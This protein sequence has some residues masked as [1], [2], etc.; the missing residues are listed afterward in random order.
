MSVF[1]QYKATY[2]VKIFLLIFTLLPTS[3][4]LHANILIQKKD[5]KFIL[6]KHLSYFSCESSLEHYDHNSVQGK[7]L[8]SDQVSPFTSYWLTLPEIDNQSEQKNWIISLAWPLLDYEIYTPQKDGTYKKFIGGADYEDGNRVLP[9][10]YYAIPLKIGPGINKSIGIKVKSLGPIYHPLK[11]QTQESFEKDNNFDLIFLSLGYGIILALLLMTLGLSILLRSKQF[12]YLTAFIFS[13]IVT[14]SILHGFAGYFFDTFTFRWFSISLLFLG[15]LTILYGENI[16]N[17]TD[18]NDP[19]LARV[20]FGVSV[21]VSFAVVF[22]AP[23]N[24][25]FYT[26]TL[27]YL[28]TIVVSLFLIIKST[29]DNKFHILTQSI[30]LCILNISG[31]FLVLFLLGFVSSYTPEYYFFIGSLFFVFYS[32]YIAAKRFKDL[33]VL[34]EN[35][36][37]ELQKQIT[38][39]TYELDHQN[40]K[41]TQV[42]DLIDEGILLIDLQGNI[43]EGFS[44]KTIEIFNTADLKLNNLGNLLQL[45]SNE[46]AEFTQWLQL[47]LLPNLQQQWKKIKQLFPLNERTLYFKDQRKTLTLDIARFNQ[48]KLMFRI[49]DITEKV[50]K[51]QALKKMQKNNYIE[52]EFIKAMDHFG[53]EAWILFKNELENLINALSN[54]LKTKNPTAQEFDSLR[55]IL[56]TVKANAGMFHME[57]IRGNLQ[58]W[59][60]FITNRKNHFTGDESSQLKLKE[61]VELHEK[62][63]KISQVFLHNFEDKYVVR[64]EALAQHIEILKNAHANLF[65]LSDSIFNLDSIAIEEFR[66]KID[67][68]AKNIAALCGKKIMP[69]SLQSDMSYI[70]KKTAVFFEGAVIQMIRNAI[71]HGIESN[72][73]RKELN[74]NTAKI[75]ITF[76]KTAERISLS[77]ADDGRGIDLEKI[78]ELDPGCS[79]KPEDIIFAK[80]FSTKMK[81]GN[82]SGMGIGL[83]KLRQDMLKFKGNIE[84][85]SHKGQGC[86]FTFWV[87]RE[88]F[89]RDI[90]RQYEFHKI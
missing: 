88:Y 41:L 54:Y 67:F 89:E 19:R 64:A 47:N 80:N 37:N 14:N 17:L 57:S 25:S 6:N 23:Y 77:V 87:N 26:S 31:L 65:Y 38:E 7:P 78:I 11:L 45:N 12:A 48:N 4:S 18:D 22:F 59:Y 13:V 62:F 33:T 75:A 58:Y 43:Q 21:S 74:K 86:I 81:K 56:H 32:L 28:T 85:L 72:R 24:M 10:R 49:D 36:T 84:V 8:N 46:Q 34:Q 44:K 35:F 1:A 82:I 66:N 63:K 51:E 15:V 70:N 3:L 39:K 69:I 52:Q 68:Y 60:E 61:L 79:G 30:P 73:E 16:L 90:L 71:D 29:I 20:F 9:Y 76:T 50:Q 55:I 27:C 42:L 2:I 53:G 5:H 40:K 83:Y